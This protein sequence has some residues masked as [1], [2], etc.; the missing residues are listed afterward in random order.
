M[1]ISRVFAV[2]VAVVSLAGWSAG[3]VDASIVIDEYSI[4]QTSPGSVSLGTISSSGVPGGPVSLNRSLALTGGPLSGEQRDISGGDLVFGIG[5]FTGAGLTETMTVGYTFGGPLN[6]LGSNENNALYLHDFDVASANASVFSLLVTVNGSSTRSVNL[7]TALPGTLVLPFSS[8]SN[9]NVFNGV[10]SIT[11]L[12]S[13]TLNS[14]GS[15]ATSS[16]SSLV[17]AP[18]PSSMLMTGLG[19]VGLVGAARRRRSA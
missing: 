4:T 6:L 8:F 5:K 17:A 10:T 18:E 9:A 14:G 1:S 11:F 16:W 15:L 19:L 3:R 7:L 12:L 2:A 13:A